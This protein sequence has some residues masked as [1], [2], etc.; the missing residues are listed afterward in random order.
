MK[1]IISLI[2]VAVSVIAIAV[3][4]FASSN[5]DSVGWYTYVDTTTAKAYASRSTSSKSVS[6]PKNFQVGV[7]FEYTEPANALWVK[8]INPQNSSTAY[9]QVKDLYIHRSAMAAGYFSSSTLKKGCSGTDVKWL[10]AFLKYLKYT[11]DTPD[12]VFGSKTETAVKKLQSD[13]G[14]TVDGL[15]G[16][17]TKVTL[18]QKVPGLYALID[19]YN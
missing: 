11:T 9:M 5:Y 6:V 14:I 1:R 12:G 18:L 13:C 4:A 17:N 19:V 8:A 16:Y 2:L 15:V 7:K 10:Q 3:P